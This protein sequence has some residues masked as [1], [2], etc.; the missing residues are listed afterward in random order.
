M[1]GFAWGGKLVPNW[2]HLQLCDLR[3][4]TQSYKMDQGYKGGENNNT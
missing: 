3:C 4:D 2:Y 1:F